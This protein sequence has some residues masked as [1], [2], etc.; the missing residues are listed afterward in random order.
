MPRTLK[1]PKDVIQMSQQISQRIANEKIISSDQMRTYIKVSFA[2]AD[3][4][5]MI[6]HD[7]KLIETVSISRRARQKLTETIAQKRGI[8]I[9]NDVRDNHMICTQK[10][11][12]RTKTR[13]RRVK[14]IRQK[15]ILLHEKAIAKHF[16]LVSKKIIS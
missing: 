9:V 1:K 15:K 6:K 8:I 2:N 13:E 12:K 5:Q 3:L 10:K 14:V 7:L 11:M 4:L 16:E